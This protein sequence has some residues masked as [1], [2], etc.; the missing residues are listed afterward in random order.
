VLEFVPEY[1]G[2]RHLVPSSPGPIAARAASSLVPDPEPNPQGH[3]TNAATGRTTGVAFGVW[4]TSDTLVLV[5]IVVLPTSPR[6]LK[7]RE[8]TAGLVSSLVGEKPNSSRK[9]RNAPNE[10]ATSN[11]RLGH[12]ASAIR[13]SRYGERI[14]QQPVAFWSVAL[15]SLAKTTRRTNRQAPG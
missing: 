13:P 9:D 2:Y 15:P 6:R 1:G 4:R 14:S 7:L 10:F 5:L 3:R 11:P 8:A 12:A